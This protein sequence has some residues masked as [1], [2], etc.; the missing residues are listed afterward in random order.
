MINYMETGKDMTRKATID[1]KKFY[2]REVHVA[3]RVSPMARKIRIATMR[4]N[5]KYN[6]YC[7]I[8]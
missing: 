8:R 7:Q 6:E 2:G 4:C 3:K 1:S 5:E